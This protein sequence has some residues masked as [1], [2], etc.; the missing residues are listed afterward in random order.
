[1]YS[2]PQALFDA[3]RHGDL[4]Q[5][6]LVL[7]REVIESQN[8][9]ATLCDHEDQCILG[10]EINSLNSD[11]ETSLHLAVASGNAECVRALLKAGADPNIKTEGGL[12]PLHLVSAVSNSEIA[13]LLL[14]NGAMVNSQSNAGGWIP[15]HEACRRGH[16]QTIKLLLSRGSVVEIP[17]DLDC[18]LTKCD[19]QPV[20]FAVCSGHVTCV[21][22]LMA[23]GASVNMP[24]GP[25][26]N[27]P[28]L[29]AIHYGQV[30]CARLLLQHGANTQQANNLGIFP[31]LKAV[32]K[33]DQS[34]EFTALLIQHGAD[35][36]QYVETSSGCRKLHRCPLYE[37]VT[38]GKSFEVLEMLLLH[39][40]DLA[41][42]DSINPNPA[43]FDVITGNDQSRLVDFINICHRHGC[44]DLKR[45]S[46]QWQR[47]IVG[48]LVFNAANWR[49]NEWFL[50]KALKIILAA[51]AS[52]TD[53]SGVS[54]IPPIK[55]VIKKRWKDA[56]CV[57]TEGNIW[58]EGELPIALE[59]SGLSLGQG[60]Q[61]IRLCSS[62][63]SLQ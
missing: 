9:P 40:A 28:L 31:V 1:M 57:M 10:M 35:V 53:A 54:N 46:N 13:Q 42:L 59:G 4:L 8:A 24:G 63:A 50:R 56:I 14:E 29:E 55:S 7:G 27:T 61:S 12:S 15:L 3:A 2:K 26:S 25:D 43:L 49:R 36:N 38:R 39:G 6:L 20:H 21:D 48:E 11:G 37:W 58:G 32:G 5:L 33:P 45:R 17:A 22:E 23:A 19:W 47:T 52:V 60:T 51:G 18:G 41:L 34:V 44:L 16:L 62:S 30:A